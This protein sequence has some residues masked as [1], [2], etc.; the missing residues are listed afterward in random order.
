MSFTHYQISY[1]E[2]AGIYHL[3]AR[4]VRELLDGAR[5]SVTGDGITY[6]ANL[7]EPLPGTKTFRARKSFAVRAR[8]RH[9]P[10]RSKRGGSVYGRARTV[11]PKLRS[12]VQPAFRHPSPSARIPPSCSIAR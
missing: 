12:R 11:R 10:T 5:T 7:G 2:L 1:P 6:D 4:E 8:Q 3:K 9:D